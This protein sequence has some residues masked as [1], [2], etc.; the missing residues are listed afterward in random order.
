MGQYESTQSLENGDD[1]SIEDRTKMKQWEQ[2]VE[3]RR[4]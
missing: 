2:I 1:L 3:N 4:L